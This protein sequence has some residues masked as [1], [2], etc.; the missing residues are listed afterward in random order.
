MVE[1]QEPGAK[2]DI[3]SGKGEPVL[4]LKK[5]IRTHTY[6]ALTISTIFTLRKASPGEEAEGCV[7]TAMY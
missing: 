3:K 2:S 7:S 1:N 6:R 5:K 4:K